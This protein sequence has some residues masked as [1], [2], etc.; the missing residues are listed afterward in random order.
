MMGSYNTPMALGRE[1]FTAGFFAICAP[2]LFPVML[3]IVVTSVSAPDGALSLTASWMTVCVAVALQFAALSFWSDMIGAGPFAGVMSTTREWILAAIVAGP[4]ILFVPAML[5]GMMM[6]EQS[7]W[8]YRDGVDP[9]VFERANWTLSFLFY[10]VI[11]APVVEEVTF[12]G[13]A[14]GAAIARGISPVIAAII[15]SAA[16]TLPHMQY[17]LPAMFAVF[18]TGLGLAALRLLSGTVIVP[19]V[20]HMSANA[21]SF[22]MQL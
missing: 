14:M 16:F 22:L 11:L 13:V 7:N 12:R 10:A 8:V 4:F 18:V 9:E 20:A 15:A 21:A 3:V 19:I 1:P 2:I 6:P 17:T 5:V